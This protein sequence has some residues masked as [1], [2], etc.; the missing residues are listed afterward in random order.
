MSDGNNIITTAAGSGLYGNLGDGGPATSAKLKTTASI[1]GDS[2]GVVY[3]VDKD[4]NRINQISL[5]GAINS[6]MTS[7]VMS[8]LQGIWVDP[9]GNRFYYTQS[10]QIRLAVFST[11]PV[12]IVAGSSG[13]GYTGFSSSGKSATS[14]S[15]WS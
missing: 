11:N 7:A 6:V 2:S 3:F 9:A 12:S 1:S 8:S 13:F 15:S 4:N 10:N 5:S 14:P